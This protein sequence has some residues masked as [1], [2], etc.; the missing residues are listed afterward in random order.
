MAEDSETSY[1][2]YE[3]LVEEHVLS[4]LLLGTIGTVLV[5]LILLPSTCCCPRREKDD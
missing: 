4:V 5:L 2:T 3:H 1:E